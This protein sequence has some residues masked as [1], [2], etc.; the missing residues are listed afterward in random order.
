MGL[1]TLNRATGLD[2]S[3]VRA[4]FPALKL[5]VNGLP[6]AFMDGPGGT[7]VPQRVIDAM[8][9]YLVNSNANTVGAFLTSERND[10]MLAEAHGA[11]A[12]LLGCDADEVFFGQNTTTNI[13]S[14]SRS[15]GRE[16]SPGDEIVVTRLD[17]DANVTPW[18]LLQEQGVVVRQADIHPRDCTLDLDDVAAKIT[19]RTRL[20]AAGYAANA[21]G[22]INP[23]RE[24]VRLAHAAG[25]L[26][27]I[28]AVH[29]APHGAIDVRALDCDFLACS[30]YKFFGP[31]CG[32]LYGKR[33]HLQRLRPYKVRAQYE[34][35]PD[36]WE[37][38]TLP[39][40][41][42][43]GACACIE[44][45]AD[46]GRRSNPAAASRREA[47]L[48]AFA[49]IQSHEQ[50][51]VPP[52]VSGLLAIPGLTL[53]GITDPARF[54]ERTPTVAVRVK[55]HHP[56]ELAR[57]LGE[58]GIFTW[59]GHYFAIDIAERLGVASTGGFLRI[60]LVHYNTHAEVDRVV[61]E[62][63]QIACRPASS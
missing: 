9:D 57:A 11:L 59:D 15:L 17:H 19:P 24:I 30:P 29:Y 16:L 46:L 42:I 33:E 62:L 27:F 2:Q 26:A 39:H 4:Q 6:V 51:L 40:E 38:G 48:A 60:G 18:R 49:A 45:L 36:R 61:A 34:R 35:L 55:G 14:L 22:T 63:R 41:N 47:L 37:T 43:A 3:W 25:A 52:L 10:A 58:R 13:L 56:L 7:Q 44:Y 1:E 23:V 32:V 12:D 54:A 8:V 50:A 21:T 53:Y 31:H 20:V 28:D 5:Q